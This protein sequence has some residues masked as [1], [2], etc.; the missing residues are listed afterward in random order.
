ME[1]VFFSDDFKKWVNSVCQTRYDN[2]PEKDP[3]LV[4]PFFDESGK[5]IAAQGRALGSHSGQTRYITVKVH[6]D[7]KKIYGLDRWKKDQL[8]YVVE[9]PIDSMFIP[10]CLAIAGGDLTSI[11][12]DKKNTVLIFDN[13]PRN[14][15][16]SKKVYQALNDEWSVVIWKERYAYKIKDINDLVMRGMENVQLVNFINKNT[17]NGVNALLEYSKWNRT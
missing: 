16:T 11:K 10:N 8:T 2:L 9:G 12:L 3:R 1:L 6:E 5:L 17:F 14:I 7:A 13:E 15:H 4:I